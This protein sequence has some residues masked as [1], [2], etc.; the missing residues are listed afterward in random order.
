MRKHN[1]ISLIH[2]NLE[3][4]SAAVQRAAQTNASPATPMQACRCDRWG[5]PCTAQ[6][7]QQVPNSFMKRGGHNDHHETKFFEIWRRSESFKLVPFSNRKPGQARGYAEHN[8]ENAK[9]KPM[10]L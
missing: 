10:N 4:T 6:P 7:E 5:H 8:R 3:K 2:A 9:H 1:L